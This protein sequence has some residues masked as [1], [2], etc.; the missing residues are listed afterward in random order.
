[1]DEEFHYDEYFVAFLDIL[2]FKDLV[3][4]NLKKDKRR[5]AKYFSI[6]ETT[7]SRLKASSEKINLGFQIISDSVIL[8]MPNTGEKEDRIEKLK[9][10][11]IAVGRI[12]SELV[13]GNLWLRGGISNGLA[14]FDYQKN[15]VLGKG[16]INAYQLESTS[17]VYPRVILDNKLIPSL[18]C[19]AAQE[20]IDKINGK[21]NGGLY[22]NWSTNILFDWNCSKYVIKNHFNQDVALFI[23]YLP[24]SI[25]KPKDFDNIIES[26]RENIY[27][28][29]KIYLK[30]RW[31]VEY[32]KICCEDYIEKNSTES[33]IY[34]SK[35]RALNYL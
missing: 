3:F 16:Y 24:Q 34:K 9:H 29:E 10:L 15:I 8:S 7:V 33:V 26:I 11:C 35:L 2:G 22:K 1:M 32:L 17:A 28:D 14:Y 23:D 20:L 5:I 12:Q 6:V 25:L 18:E 19:V 27:K 4:S 21:S 30:Y 31:V 13:K